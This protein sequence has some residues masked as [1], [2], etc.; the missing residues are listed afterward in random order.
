MELA[1][2]PDDEG[3]GGRTTNNL[4]VPSVRPLGG[5]KTLGAFRQID[6]PS[7]F[8]APIAS[9]PER[10]MQVKDLP[11]WLWAA[12]TP[13]GGFRDR[14]IDQPGI[15]D[16]EAYERSLILRLKLQ[17]HLVASDR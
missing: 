3:Q 6:E 2:E 7:A 17:A 10:L 12:N 9:E 11:A 14:V 16:Y 5:L 1:G 15:C 8:S 13:D 4:G